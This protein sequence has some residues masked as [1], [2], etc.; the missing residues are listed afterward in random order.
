MHAGALW[1]ARGDTV[2]APPPFSPRTPL[3]PLSPRLPGLPCRLNNCQPSPGR[4]IAPS[5]EGGTIE[6]NDVEPLVFFTR[7]VWTADI[8]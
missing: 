6:Y 3:S 5:N 8:R 1:Q 7:I 4:I 2:D